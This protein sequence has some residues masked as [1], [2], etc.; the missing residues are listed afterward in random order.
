MDD[1]EFPIFAFVELHPKCIVRLVKVSVVG[2]ILTQ[3][4]AED[5]K[6]APGFV[7]DIVE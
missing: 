1:Q 3:I 2:W 6:G 5:L 7:A 4:V